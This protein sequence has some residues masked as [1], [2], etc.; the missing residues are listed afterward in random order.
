MHYKNIAQSAAEGG[1][2]ETLQWLKTQKGF[3]LNSVIIFGL[4]CK[5]GN[6]EVLKWLRRE[7]CRWNEEA[8]TQAAFSGHLEMLKWLRSEGCPLHEWTCYGAARGGHL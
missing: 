5:S 4:A 6:L 2:L 3:K 8:C 7:G 1:Q